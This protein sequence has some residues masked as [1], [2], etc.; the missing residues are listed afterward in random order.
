MIGDYELFIYSFLFLI[1]NYS[2]NQKNK[3]DITN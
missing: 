1:G 3:T 2:D